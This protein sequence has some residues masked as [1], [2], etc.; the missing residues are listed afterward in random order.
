M[1]DGEFGVAEN[2]AWRPRSI[3]VVHATMALGVLL[4][5]AMCIVT[6]TGNL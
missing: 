5:L 2:T 3:S 4:C 1:A 6:L